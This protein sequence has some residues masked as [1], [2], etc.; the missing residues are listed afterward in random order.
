[1]RAHA[2][3][4]KSLNSKAATGSSSLA[5]SSKG[6]TTAGS[7]PAVRKGFL[8]SG[9]GNSLYGEE[10]SREGGGGLGRKGKNIDREFERLVTEADPDMVN[11]VRYAYLPL[12]H[13]FQGV[14][15]DSTELEGRSRPLRGF[16][17]LAF[18]RLGIFC[19][20]AI[21]SL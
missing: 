8:E 14:S 20:F 12:W 16:C 19:V 7:R 13:I 4:S 18:K 6:K 2:G 21:F 11:Q 10:G 3:G 1:M 5:S 15:L 17:G 9:G